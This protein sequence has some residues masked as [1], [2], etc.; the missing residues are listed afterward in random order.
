MIRYIIKCTIA[1]QQGSAGWWLQSQV[2]IAECQVWI[3]EGATFCLSL[4]PRDWLFKGSEVGEGMNL[5]VYSTSWNCENDGNVRSLEEISWMQ[6]G[7]YIF[8]CY[9]YFKKFFCCDCFVYTW[10]MFVLWMWSVFRSAKWWC[11]LLV[12]VV[13]MLREPPRV[14][15]PG[16]PTKCGKRWGRVRWRMTSV[17]LWRWRVH[18]TWLV[19]GCLVAW[20]LVLGCRFVYWCWW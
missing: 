2:P 1:K 3:P 9:Y 20:G 19:W 11:P 6:N 17:W 8:P 14:P 7:L 15:T 4:L 5:C 18:G 12:V 16:N 10:L 13:R